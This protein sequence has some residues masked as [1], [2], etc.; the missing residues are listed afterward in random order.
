MKVSS[1]SIKQKV[2]AVIFISSFIVMLATVGIFVYYQIS[3]IKERTV[4]ELMGLADVIGT[5]SASAVIFD[6]P[7]AAR[8]SLS[9]LKVDKDIDFAC[10]FRTDGGIFV[11]YHPAGSSLENYRP[12]LNEHNDVV[13]K[14]DHILVYSEIDIAGD[15]V[16][17][18]AIRSGMS[19][20]NESINKLLYVAMGII[21]ASFVLIFVFS[22]MLQRLVTA[23]LLKLS[24]TAEQIT[25]TKDYSVRAEKSADDEVGKV[26]ETFNRMLDEIQSRDA[27]L[28]ETVERRTSELSRANEELIRAKEIAEDAN[29]AKSIFLANMSHEIR[30]PMNSILGF[31]ELLEENISDPTDRRHLQTIQSS[32]VTL[33]NLINDIL[34]LSKI[35][36]GKMELN[37]EPI[38]IRGL[39]GEIE[40]IFAPEVSRK[41][42]DFVKDIQSD[43]PPAFMIDGIRLRQVLMNLAGNAVKF[44]EEGYVKVTL[45]GSEQSEGLWRLRFDVADT[46]IGIEKG[47]L[48]EI[49][50]AFHQQKG[51]DTARFGGTGLGLSITKKI[52]DMMEGRISV[53]SSTGAGSTFSIEL[54]GVEQTELRSRLSK[55]STGID[56]DFNG[57][58]V[59][60]VDDS[61]YNRILLKG[62]LRNTNIEVLEAANGKEALRVLE[63]SSVD[64][65]LLDIRMPVMDGYQTTAAIRRDERL[66]GIPVVIVTASV[67]KGAER[68]A[69]DIGCDGYLRKPLNKR[70]VLETIADFIEPAHIEIIKDD[71]PQKVVRDISKCR[72]SGRLY[73]NL[74]EE[75]VTRWEQ[76][77][78][79]YI[80]EDLADFGADMKRLGESEKCPPVREWGEALEGAASEFDVEAVQRLFD[81]FKKMINDLQR[82]VESP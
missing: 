20:L 17:T 50:E 69:E 15:I 35:E 48:E 67:M 73:E 6:D 25:E 81:E 42:I 12:A 71:E 1:L 54:E 55:T 9:A 28:E 18:V 61:E 34:D 36:A 58:T 11:S 77:R 78:K 70:D 62:Y 38:D 56:V 14:S 8:E 31:T 46:G 79:S 65:V 29:R 52:V 44:T 3:D 26:I 40:G 64:L 68:K 27:H 19:V 23:P 39:M 72:I 51:Q 66:R 76:L 49:F 4:Q 32:G 57:A 60:V 82:A 41:R 43:L 21:S 80:V 5:S 63:N 33:L 13:F 45:T 7:A 75:S 74:I 37:P 59:L 22:G 24:E 10:I 47:Q 30:T 16:G 53:R 2:S